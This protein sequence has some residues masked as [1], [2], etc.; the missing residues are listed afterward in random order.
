M[1]S[2]RQG[3]LSVVTAVAVAGTA[4]VRRVPFSKACICA[5]GVRVSYNCHFVAYRHST[6]TA[7]C[8]SC[9]YQQ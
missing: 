4:A 3:M 2:C 7:L 9:A 1:W 6:V 5:S 8:E